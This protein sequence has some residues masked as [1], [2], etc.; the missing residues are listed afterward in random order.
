SKGFGYEEVKE[1]IKVGLTAPTEV[2]YADWLRNVKIK[3]R[4]FWLND[5]HESD[6]HKDFTGYDGKAGLETRDYEL[7][8]YAR[9]KGYQPI[10]IKR[11]ELKKDELDLSDFKDLRELVCSGNKLTSLNLSDCP[12]LV[13]LKC[14][15]NQLT[16]L[17]LSQNIQL[18]RLDC[19]NNHLVALKLVKLACSNNKL[20]N[21]DFLAI[22]PNPEKLIYLDLGNNNLNQD[23]AVFRRFEPLAKSEEL[24]SLNI[25]NTNLNGGVEHLSNNLLMKAG[26]NPNDYKFVSWL[27]DIQKDELSG[28]VP[29]YG[30]SRDSKGNYI[31]VMEYMKEGNLRQYLQ[32][33]Y[34]E[35][36]FND[37]TEQLKDIAKGLKDIHKKN[38]VHKDFHSGNI[39]CPPCRITD[40]GLSK[41]VNEEEKGEKIFGVLPYVAPEV[42]SG[43]PYTPAADIYS[44]GMI[45]YEVLTGLAPYYNSAHDIDLTMLICRGE[46]PK[47]QIKIPEPLEILIKRYTEFTRQVQAVDKFN[48]TLPDEIRFPDYKSQSGIVLTS[49]PINTKQISK[50]LYGTKDLDLNLDMLGEMKIEDDNEIEQ[51]AQIE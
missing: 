38:L 3:C 24:R 46:R 8:T 4:C 28:I 42:L 34:R 45:A 18:K 44:F 20:V 10:H 5:Q 6:I 19:F 40:L 31:M 27:R 1:W 11:K 39:L 36:N 26:A 47:F 35:L 48:Q 43:K 30:I 49:K 7:V 17:N 22:L 33:H 41:P 25:S 9:Y 51:I 2:S 32:K 37:K 16:N 21:C 12:N 50:L 14:D 23:L 13:A 15:R 29:C